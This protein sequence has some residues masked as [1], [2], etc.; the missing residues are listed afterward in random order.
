MKKRD[1]EAMR[2]RLSACDFVASINDLDGTPGV[3]T[4]CRREVDRAVR[5]ERRAMLA[6]MEALAKMREVRP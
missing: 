3:A 2:K 6:Q 1:F 5:E 4:M